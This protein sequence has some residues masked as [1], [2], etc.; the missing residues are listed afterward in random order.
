MIIK[1]LLFPPKCFICRDVL[2]V[3]QKLPNI[4]EKCKQELDILPIRKCVKCKKP[5]DVGYNKAY[6]LY[7]TH[8][9]SGIEGVVAPFLYDDKIRSS[10][11][12]FKFGNKPYYARSYALYMYERLQKYG[13]S[14]SFDA[15][16]PVP[17]SRKRKSKRGY[18]Q[19]KCVAKEISKLLKIPLIDAL[20]K[21][22]ECPPQSTLSMNERKNN[23]RNAYAMKK[24][25]S[26]LNHVLLID[27]I[28]TTGTTVSECIKTLKKGGIK[29]ATV[30]TIA[31]HL[32]EEGECKNSPDHYMVKEYS[33]SEV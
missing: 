25:K 33:Y 12:R 20:K 21:I 2:P 29:R 24:V 26:L 15:V 17:I 22:K 6:C 8:K 27:D 23:V 10:I 28:Y 14:D 7:C 1:N 4:C 16:I 11:L 13:I 18:N 31:I 3:T 9:I 5:M 30:C 32:P 19:S